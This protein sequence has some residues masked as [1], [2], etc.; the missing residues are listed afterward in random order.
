[1]GRL[2][3]AIKSFFKALRDPKTVKALLYK[4]QNNDVGGDVSHIDV[5]HLR[6]LSVLQSSG[7]LID[8]LKE[9]ITPYTDAQV[10]AVMRKI[11]SD[12]S[13]SIEDL[14]TVRS[15]FKEPEGATVIVPHG[16][17]PL[18]IKV[19]GNV[20]GNPPY[21]GVVRHRGWKAHKLSLPKQTTTQNR[22][23]IAPAEVEIV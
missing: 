12:C 16:Y 11:H 1:M 18:Q 8:F 21:K 20:K 22:D 17:D 2:L 5:S 7:R 19:V 10:G 9:N 6:L 14:V 13:A 3:L 15:V 23:I 4:E